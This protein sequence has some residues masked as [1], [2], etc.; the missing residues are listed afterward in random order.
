[1]GPD[2][3]SDLGPFRSSN[4]SRDTT[5]L[6]RGKRKVSL[7]RFV[8]VAIASDGTDHGFIGS[9]RTERGR[10][11]RQWSC[12]GRLGGLESLKQQGLTLLLVKLLVLD[13]IRLDLVLS[14][15]DG[16]G[17]FAISLIDNHYSQPHV[18]F[19]LDGLYRIVRS[20]DGR[21]VAIGRS[22][23]HRAAG[24]RRG[25]HV[26]DV[27][28]AGFVVVVDARDRGCFCICFDRDFMTDRHTLPSFFDSTSQSVFVVMTLVWLTAHK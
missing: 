25:V 17:N 23:V 27:V 10:K 1:M 15:L 18:A 16:D 5:W 20:K 2:L 4:S 3:S 26:E 19:G 8:T 24:K 14:L 21:A 6:Q 28:V 11:D 9:I 7:G 12:H 22:H 13:G